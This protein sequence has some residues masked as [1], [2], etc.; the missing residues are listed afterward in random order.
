MTPTDTPSEVS[1]RHLRL[2][3]ANVIT[4]VRQ[5]AS[6]IVAIVAMLEPAVPGATHTVLV[7]GLAAWAIYRLI[8]RSLSTIAITG[9][10][11]WV[12]VI[13]GAIPILATAPGLST[14][15]SV[16]QAIVAVSI[17]TLGVQLSVRW[18]MAALAVGACAFT[19]GTT[20]LAGWDSG[21]LATD[22]TAI[23]GGWFVAVLFRLTIGRVARTAD[24]AHQDRLGT[25]VAN[26]IAAA[27]RNCDREQLALLHDT[28][29]ATLL[30]VGHTARVPAA[31]VA[32]LASRD[33]AVL[34]AL[35]IHGTLPQ[36]D[37][38]RL[39]RKEASHLD[40]PIEF[41]GLDHLW[42]DSERAAALCAASREAL[43]NIARHADASSVTVYAGWKR[44]EISDNGRGFAKGASR[45]H[46]IDDSIVA[47]MHRIGGSAR[48]RSVPG[49]GTTV[50][51]RWLDDSAGSDSA[52]S[53]NGAND[54]LLHRLQS[55]YRLTM[56]ALATLIVVS[57]VVR[58]QRHFPF[59]CLQIGLAVATVMFALAA[60]TPL[61]RHAAR[62][63]AWLVAAG[64]AG[65]VVLQRG[66][67]GESDLRTYADWSLGV[68]GFCLL[69]HLLRS[70]ATRCPAILVAVWAP[71]A[72]LDVIRH[73][74]AVMIADLGLGAATFLI[75]QIGACLF[76]ASI[77]DGL[78]AARRENDE[79]LRLET[80]EAIAEAM[81]T[82][83]IRRYSGTVDRLVPLL[84]ILSQGGP[85]TEELRRRARV[86]CHRL[87]WLFDESAPQQ[88]SLSQR[89][90]SLIEKAEERGVNVSAFVDGDLPT[91]PRDATEQL[92]SNVHAALDQART[93]ARL[94]LTAAPHTEVDLSVVCDVPNKPSAEMWQ[95]P[96]GMDVV[97]AED[98]MWMT[99]RAG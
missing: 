93:W 96:R 24:Q 71:F 80:R 52:N 22:L 51:L 34:Q 62:R 13:G 68:I 15:V 42:L 75:P 91:L 36:V 70:S 43:T 20:M 12:V 66:I 60:A 61:A 92:L 38:V 74:S 55:Q 1:R 16:P 86:E 79:R 19:W 28:A 17:A 77:W 76:S 81:Q 78:S 90:Q 5:C 49:V 11:A 29:A 39:L 31:R 3:S 87:R 41:T 47:R 27:R 97:V 82:D 32:A 95:R 45:G 73:P 50:E 26:G 9:D 72:I 58:A 14:E 65:I 53:G 83:H 21:V 7:T 67:L 33:L 59:P 85:I 2:R 94:I 64:L 99:L 56:I 63:R 10:V 46:G 8:T 40:S 37:V 25:E 98:K 35:P 18:S 88:A 54:Q 69:P 23:A 44:L 4:V 89:I 57:N 30:L 84:R 48:I 6:L